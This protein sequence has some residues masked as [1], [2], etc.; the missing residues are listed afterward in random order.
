MMD[1]TAVILAGG[2]SKRMGKD[3]IFLPLGGKPLFDYVWEVCRSVFEEV[4]VIT[5][6]PQRFSSYPVRVE[7]DLLPGGVLGGIYTG[8]EAIH[9]PYAF[10]VACDVPFLRRELVD[11][12]LSLKDGFDAVVPIAPDGLHPLV[13][14]YSKGC[15]R[16]MKDAL[17]KGMLRVAD[18]FPSLRVR[19]CHPDEIR[20]L[21]PSFL[22]FLNVNTEEDLK[23]AQEILAGGFPLRK[24]L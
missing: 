6:Y 20:P 8:L 23:K 14:V 12:L 16:V 13:A 9:T 11:Y 2:R 24:A 5:N 18:V 3:K 10:C 22:S 21:D 19:F 4:L 17:E 1:T 15:S 7:K